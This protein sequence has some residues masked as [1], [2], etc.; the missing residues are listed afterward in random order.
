MINFIRY[1]IYASVI[2]FSCVTCIQAQSAEKKLTFENPL[3]I[4][5][6][7]YEPLIFPPD[8]EVKGMDY[9]VT[10]AV[11]H[12]LGV[13][14]VIK[15]YPFKRCLL[16]VKNKQA[17]AVI[18][19]LATPKRRDY[20]FFPDE[21]LSESP[22]VVFHL[23]DKP[24]EINT[25][26][27]LKL[28]RVGAQLGF[29]YPNGLSQFL[30]N[31]Q[32]VSTIEQ[33]LTKLLLNRID[34]IVENRIV[35]LYAIKNMGLSRRV[36][37]TDLPGEFLNRYFIGFAKKKGYDSLSTQFNQALIQFKK[38]VAYKEILSKYGQLE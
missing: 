12:I 1:S 35:G 17:D 31:Q 33:N 24:L 34:I 14:F 16:M 13:P 4:V 8:A 2:L 36:T 21:P 6:E 28:Y 11:F 32:K 38:T 27:D 22:D 26:E 23:T 29:E 37:Y 25:L 7:A 10:E 19:L 15:F 20:I 3:F 5:T 18:D 9:E 30:V